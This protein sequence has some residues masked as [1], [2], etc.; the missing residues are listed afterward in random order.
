MSRLGRLR[1]PSDETIALQVHRTRPQDIGIV[2]WNDPGAR[3][4]Q[5][6]QTIG[7]TS[8]SV[9]IVGEA[10]EAMVLQRALKVCDVHPEDELLANTDG[11]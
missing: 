2:A 1:L 5:L 3:V 10:R 7:R 9:E 8:L 11:L 6:A 4:A